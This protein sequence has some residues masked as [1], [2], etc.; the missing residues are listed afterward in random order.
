MR[1]IALTA[2]FGLAFCT[3]AEAQRSEKWHVGFGAGISVLSGTPARPHPKQGD[4]ITGAAGPES[5]LH[6]HAL[7]GWSSPIP[8]LRLE[9]E[10]FWDRQTTS[11]RTFNCISDD[12]DGGAA[13]GTCYP[14]AKTDTQLGIVIGPRVRLAGLP[15]KPVVLA[16]LGVARYQLIADT[17]AFPGLVGAEN[18]RPI[19]T[20]GV[21]TEVPLGPIKLLAE[22]RMNTSLGRGGG[23]ARIPITITLVR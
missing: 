8:W 22:V 16:G 3:T 6:V 5:G 1:R 14:A 20:V 19:Y 23:V 2:V 9:T 7:A 21:G 13:T 15:L 18:V 10:L 17:V 4:G 12:N 11:E